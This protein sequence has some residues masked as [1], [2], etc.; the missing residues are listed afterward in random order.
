MIFEPPHDHR[1][2]YDDE[3]NIILPSEGTKDTNSSPQHAW[4]TIEEDE[5]ESTEAS[6]SRLTR[7]RDPAERIFRDA[8]SNMRH[9]FQGFLQ[10]GGAQ[11]RWSIRSI[12][13]GMVQSLHSLRRSLRLLWAFLTQPVWIVSRKR[14][15]PKKYSRLTLFVLD[16]VRFGGTF[17]ALFV[18]LFVS[19]NYQSFWQ[20]SQSYLNPLNYMQS[21][22]SRV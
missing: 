8:R 18:A 21:A 11:Y 17:A 15:T 14:Q 4:T 1:A 22:N 12:R 19:L 10:E 3:G 9:L 16:T 20:I 6:R 13:K 5:Q 2:E 7:R